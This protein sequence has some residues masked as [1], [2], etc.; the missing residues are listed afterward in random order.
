M[1]NCEAELQGLA[2]E[3]K[4]FE[5]REYAAILPDLWRRRDRNPGDHDISQLI[6]DSYFNLALVDLQRGDPAA[7]A[8]KLKDALEVDPDDEDLRRLSLFATAYSGRTQDLLYLIF[9]KYLPS[10][11]L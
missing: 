10:R 5:E 3:I 7:A 8:A 1:L 2:K 4:K 9:V 6:T 11:D